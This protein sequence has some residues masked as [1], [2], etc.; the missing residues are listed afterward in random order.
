MDIHLQRTKSVCYSKLFVFKEIKG[1]N[2]VKGPY[3]WGKNGQLFSS[4]TKIKIWAEK[5]LKELTS[6]KSAIAV[7]PGIF[8][9]KKILAWY[10]KNSKYLFIANCNFTLETQLFTISLKPNI[11]NRS[12]NIKVLYTNKSQFGYK[13]KIIDN[14]L[15]IRLEKGEVLILEARNVIS[16]YCK[17]KIIDSKFLTGDKSGSAF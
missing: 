4:I 16:G 14:R 1:L 2:A 17:E 12:T 7:L 9:E 6:N 13:M 8:S 5:I 15:S 11:G 3:E 10:Y